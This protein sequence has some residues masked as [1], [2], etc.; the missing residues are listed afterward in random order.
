M[1]EKYLKREETGHLLPKWRKIRG[2]FSRIFWEMDFINVTVPCNSC[3]FATLSL[4]TI[5]KLK[6]GRSSKP[7]KNFLFRIHKGFFYCIGNFKFIAKKSILWITSNFRK[8]W[9]SIRD[10][11]GSCW[12]GF[13][14]VGFISPPQ[15]SQEKRGGT[16][17][18][19]SSMISK[20]STTF[21]GISSV[22]LHCWQR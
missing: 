4:K 14:L 5:P 8:P 2:F 3:F 13:Q 7:S 16:V 11:K 17:G 10:Q 6:P 19:P 20:K 15:D 21:L 22:E 12:K 1:P 18:S 9:V